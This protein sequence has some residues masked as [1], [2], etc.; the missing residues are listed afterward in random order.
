MMKK[1]LI[2]T[3]VAAAVVLSTSAVFAA[4]SP[5]NLDGSIA[6]Q[7]RNNTETGSPSTKFNKTTLLLNA[8]SDLGNGWGVYGR[9]AAQ[10]GNGGT[11]FNGA[12]Y[13]SGTQ[14]VAALDQFGFNYKT[15]DTTAKIG[16]QAFTLGATGLIYDTSGYLGK[17][18]FADGVTVTGKTGVVNY[19]AA[20]L[21]EDIAYPTVEK[22]KI[23][24]LHADYAVTP[25]FT[26]GATFGKYDS[27]YVTSRNV[28][29][30]NAAYNI[31]PASFYTEYAK[32]NMSS[33]NKAYDF[34]V[35]YKFDDKNSASVTAFRVENNADF[36]GWTTWD[37]NKKGVYYTFS[38]KFTKDTALSFLYKDI[39]DISSGVTDTSFRTTV[40]YNF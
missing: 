7:Y 28:W 1:S 37:L 6:Y 2:V 31:G 12:A 5:V 38:H 8:N 32:T 33:D 11:D 22:N 19:Q 16:R 30:L 39:K 35:S 13:A 20:A 14:Y 21:K 26:F 17:H 25:D 3:A 18:Q 29:A 34:G 9:V 27:G 15:G 23:Y 4:E 10:G 24:A 40:S 36:N